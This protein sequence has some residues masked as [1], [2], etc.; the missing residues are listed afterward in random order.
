[1][2]SLPTET[3]GILGTDFIT[4]SGA[5][6]DFECCKLLINDNGRWSRVHS[7]TPTGH[8]ALTNFTEGTEGHIQQPSIQEVRQAKEPLAASPHCEIITQGKTCLVKTKE[9]HP[10]AQMPSGCDGKSRIGKEQKPLQTYQTS[11]IGE[12]MRP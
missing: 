5:M 2:F 11:P 10:C 12:K 4:Q 3:A 7:D 1:M 6:I 9:C 8:N